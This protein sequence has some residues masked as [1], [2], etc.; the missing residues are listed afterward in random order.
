M[1]RGMQS[2]FGRPHL[3][4][5]ALALSSACGGSGS[6]SG[7]GSAGLPSSL[8]AG[9]A[10]GFNVLVVTLDTTRADRI[11]CYGKTDAETPAI[12]SLAAN[13]VRFADAV[14]VAPVTLPS[15]ATIFTG[16]TPPNHGVRDN[17]EYKLAARHQ[18]LA[19][20]LKDA[21]YD[22]AAFLAAFVLDAR[23][24]LDQGFDLYD[25]RLSREAAYGDLAERSASDVTDSALGWLESRSETSPFFM[26]VHYF[27]P[28]HPYTPPA[29][30]AQ[31]FSQSLYDGEIA[32]M[33]RQLGR[34]LEGLESRG[35][36]E[37][38][39]VVV[40][41]DH[42][43]SLG[44][45]EEAT[46]GML[47]YE[48]VMH[49]P[50]IVS[51]PA[52]TQG[53]YVIDDVVVSTTDVTPTILELLGIDDPQERDGMSLLAAVNEPDRI[54]YMESL[55]PFIESGWSPLYGLRRHGDKL[56]EAPRREYYDL[57][58]DPTEWNN[59]YGSSA[60]TGAAELQAELK[61]QMAEA[62]SIEGST[63][64]RQDL[65]LEALA[66]LESLGYVAGVAPDERSGLENPKDMMAVMQSVGRAE[67]LIEQGK[68][69]EALLLTQEAERRSPRHRRVLL[70]KATVEAMMGRGQEAL[71][72]LETF[73]SIRPSADGHLLAAQI[74]IA[75]GSIT[76]AEVHLASA[77]A[78]DPRHGGV[79][80]ARGDILAR[81]GDEAAARREYERA[82]EVDPN[83]I[84][85]AARARIAGLNR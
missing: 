67:S 1:G 78:L 25:D 28:H 73:T 69:R 65:D 72:T 49:V 70:N 51:S 20:S 15:H 48:S 81:A 29:A 17:S 32:A 7:G 41:A 3:V 22:T 82:I 58:E 30:Q 74:L 46:H 50:L 8:A 85:S 31:R 77:A 23:F 76:K 63:D 54:A 64:S 84:T 56:I 11:G 18:T 27:D 14:T 71:K 12:D 13:G 33:D 26:W 43:E 55:T 60:A 59:R 66:K 38:T 35:Q 21:G 36:K 9:A 6:G 5:A 39:L 47:I 2:C 45:H 52:L 53:A 80:I 34:L 24:G 42:G 62:P 68:L 57:V 37:R 4:I 19:E 10:A 16:L 40:V 79:F 61:R 44:E 83:R 75:D